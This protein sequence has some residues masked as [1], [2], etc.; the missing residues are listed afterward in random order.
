MEQY[1]ILRE[2]ADSWGLLLLVI[3]F[4]FVVLYTFRRSSREL[5]RDS[6]NIPF[7]HDSMPDEDAPTSGQDSEV[8]E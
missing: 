6:A 5:H 2:F 1:S 8:R 7:R 4:I 3:A